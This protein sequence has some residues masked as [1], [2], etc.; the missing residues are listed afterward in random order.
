MP[1]V[2]PQEPTV[3]REPGPGGDDETVENHPA[4]AQIVAHRVSS[5]P[6][7][8]LFDSE[9]QHGHYVT[10]QISEATRRR[11]LNR[12]WIYGGKRI[13]EVAMSEAQWAS[14]V[15][16]MNTSGVPCTL[17]WREKLSPE[18]KKLI[19]GLV[20]QQAMPD[21]WYV[22]PL[23]RLLDGQ[24][25]GLIFAPRLQE[26]MDEVRR[27][28]VKA[29]AQIKKAFEA[30]QE[31]PNKGNVR[32]LGL[33]IENAPRNMVFA[34]ESLTEHIEN[35][36]QKARADIE[37]MVTAKAEQLKIDPA[38]VGITHALDAGPTDTE[39]EEPKS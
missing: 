25:P 34:A 21:D 35:T 9:L 5:T 37:A 18:A 38:E 17:E 14:F 6:G 3:E 11:G 36:V 19:D 1:R 28:G 32:S 12:D 15:S 33:T 16:S 13:I 4:F 29:L 22:E 20:D 10:I 31:K 39:E 27:A 8:V 2:L 7:A 30:V 23:G 26:S 24:V